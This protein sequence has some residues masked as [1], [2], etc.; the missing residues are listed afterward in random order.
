MILV[1]ASLDNATPTQL[2][3]AAKL[4]RFWVDCGWKVRSSTLQV[5]TTTGY[6]T[7]VYD[8]CAYGVAYDPWTTVEMQVDSDGQFRLWNRKS[9][10]T[11]W[12]PVTVAL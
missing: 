10:W 9:G 8:H 7:M 1:H 6:V 4:Q 12:S 11:N 5:D 3:N 2:F